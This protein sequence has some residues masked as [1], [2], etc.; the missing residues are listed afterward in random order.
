MQS[1]QMQRLIIAV[2]VAAVLSWPAGCRR[3]ERPVEPLQASICAISAKPAIFDGRLVRLHA[4]VYGDGIENL[5]LIDSQCDGIGIT[6]GFD[7]GA[8]KDKVSA[9]DSV[10]A[11]YPGAAD[12]FSITATL[13][14][15]FHWH[16]NAV[17][18]GKTL[19]RIVVTEI[20]D[21]VI[22]PR[23]AKRG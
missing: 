9:I 3:R 22:V 17:G 5:I 16:P 1:N 12:N 14:G 2:A 10:V 11:A 8:P 18:R 20:S 23:A 21:L 6:L 7:A 15:T 19:R 4:Q 13:T